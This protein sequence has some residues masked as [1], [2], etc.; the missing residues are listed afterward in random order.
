[1]CTY[2]VTLNA[3]EMNTRTASEVG[4][5]VKAV[6]WYIT[7]TTTYLPSHIR[8]PAS[9]SLQLSRLFMVALCNRADQYIFAL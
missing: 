9:N 8:W 3:L 4:H 1:M 6:Q 7:Y 2:D 5:F